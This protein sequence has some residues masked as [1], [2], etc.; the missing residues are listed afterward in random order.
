MKRIKLLL[1]SLSILLLSGCKATY[2]LEIN[3]EGFKEN[4]TINA[5]SINENEK[6]KNYALAAYINTDEGDD[7]VEDESILFEKEE[8]TEYY[9]DSLKKDENG[10]NVLN[11]N[12]FFNHINFSKSNIIN[13]NFSQIIVKTYNYDE[14]AQKNYILITTPNDFSGFEKYDDLEYVTIKITNDYKVISS[15]ADEVNNNTY[16]WHLTKDNIKSISMVYDPETIEDRQNFFEKYLSS[17]F[18]GFSIVVII[19]IV[20]IAIVYLISKRRNKI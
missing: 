11:Y 10:L 3:S 17:A 18:I 2:E 14:E 13:N 6:I 9:N 5:T 8:D 4:L 19:V 1:L 15:N 20:I 12:Y 16:I 7:Y